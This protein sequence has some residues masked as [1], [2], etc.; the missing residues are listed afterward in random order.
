[1]ESDI[2]GALGQLL[3]TRDD[4][5]LDATLRAFEARIRLWRPPSHGYVV[6]HKRQGTSIQIVVLAARLSDAEKSPPVDDAALADA[7]EA[8]VQSA[9]RDG[10]RPSVPEGLERPAAGVGLRRKP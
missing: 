7:L 3:I 1:M 8:A 10:T 9:T 6:L 5:D 2:P 4:P